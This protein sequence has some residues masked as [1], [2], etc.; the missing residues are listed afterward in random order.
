MVY[1]ITS[2]TLTYWHYCFWKVHEKMSTSRLR[3]HHW[4]K[5]MADF[6]L[7]VNLLDCFFPLHI[8]IFVKSLIY[9]SWRVSCYPLNVS[10]GK[11]G[12]IK[13][14]NMFLD[15]LVFSYVHLIDTCLKRIILKFTE[16]IANEDWPRDLVSFCI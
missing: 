1:D 13:T 16:K 3:G 8:I 10:I 9:F 14:W 7:R 5:T 15:V 11:W 4:G 12:R 2:C 6:L